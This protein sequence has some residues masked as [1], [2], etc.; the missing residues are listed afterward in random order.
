ML[1]R[2]A[3]NKDLLNFVTS[4]S[5]DAYLKVE[6]NLGDGYVRLKISEAERRQAKHDIRGVE[7]IVVELLRNSRDAHAQRIFV[8]SGREGDLRTITVLDDGVGVPD[9]MTERIFE[10]RVTS[11]LETMVMD[12]WGVHGRGMALFSIRSNVTDARVVASGSHKGASVRTEA[13]VSTLSERTDQSTWPTVERDE[14]GALR[15]SRGPHNIVRRTAEFALEHPGVDVYIGTPTE[16]LSTLVMLARFEMD[17]SD[18]LFCSDPARLPVWQRPGAAADA[19]E[20]TDTASEIGLPVSERTA[21]RIL[22]GEITP[23]RSVS[24]MIAG[25]AETPGAP[26]AP[27]IYRDRRGLKIHSDDLRAFRADLERAFDAVA[28]KYYLHLKCEPKVTV[29]SQDIRVRFEVDKEE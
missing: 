24:A 28:E 6:E 18:L 17:E 16:V 11:K 5:G 19:L 10:P 7:D 9:G 20:L 27:D 3:D 25:G 15:V 22:G 26:D 2:M 29:G 21:F 14:S 8:A 4:V 13:D 23:L 12:R 1:S